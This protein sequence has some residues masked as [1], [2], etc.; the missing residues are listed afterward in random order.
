MT[1]FLT[2]M[3]LQVVLILAGMG[4]VWLVSGRRRG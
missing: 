3:A 2:D 1:D 4:T